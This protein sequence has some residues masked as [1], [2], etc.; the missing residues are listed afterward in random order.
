MQC[1]KTQCQTVYYSIN[2]GAKK[3]TMRRAADL[4]LNLL[5]TQK[6]Y[7]QL[8]S[9]RLSIDFRKNRLRGKKGTMGCGLEWG[10]RGGWLGCKGKEKGRH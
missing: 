10:C 1:Y 8:R 7:V 5:L 9:V 3:C 2:R 4:S 6:Q